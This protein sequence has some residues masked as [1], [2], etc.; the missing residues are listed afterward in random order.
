M[1]DRTIIILQPP[2]LLPLVKIVDQ[3]W[4]QKSD[5]GAFPPADKYNITSVMRYALNLTDKLELF[6]K[7]QVD[8]LPHNMTKQ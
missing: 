8:T 4:W 2:Q 3:L 7:E 5:R 1:N 6:D